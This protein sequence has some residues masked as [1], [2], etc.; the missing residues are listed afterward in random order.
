M[1]DVDTIREEGIGGLESQRRHVEALKSFKTLFD[2]SLIG[3]YILQDGKFQFVNKP[4][5]EI[6]GYVEN[7]L[8]GTDSLSLVHPEDRSMVRECAVKMLKG[9]R[10]S[11]YEYRVTSKNGENRWI[12]ETVVSIQYLGRRAVLGNFLDI[13]DHKLVEEELKH[14]LNKLQ[15]SNAE[16]EQFA[17]IASH[18]LQEPLRMVASYT[19]LL[20]RRYQG[21]LDADADEFI[22]YAVDGA[23]RMKKLID[24]L[25][26]YSRI[27][28][29]SGALKLTDCEDIV[30]EALSNLQLAIEESDAIVIR[31]PL[32]TVMVDSPQL[33]RL[34]QNLI[35]NAIKFRRGP[36]PEI[37][38][39]ATQSDGDW[40]FSV[41]DNGI[42]IDMK[43]AD[44]IFLIFQRLHG[45]TEY[46]GT[47]IGLAICKK[48]VDRHGGRIWVEP[49]DNNGS[50]FYFTIPT[51]E[52]K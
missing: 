33:V 21:Q 34:F 36:E 10:T 50:T 39:G 28:T 22:A 8:L 25:L 24:D 23:N 16:L 32:P 49:N 42:G 9:E 15:H 47:G 29:K 3:L 27:N 13:T 46:P 35:G 40:I 5:Q 14:T 6:S 11:Y 52:G 2:R 18:D 51:K 4:F 37:Q 7:E 44:R 38:I 26:A 19:Q 45:K 20:S 43:Q 48:I 41:R 12:I 30:D 1:I 31:I 17:Y